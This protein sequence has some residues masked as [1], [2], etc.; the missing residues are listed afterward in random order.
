MHVVQ[1]PNHKYHKLDTILGIDSSVKIGSCHEFGY[2]LNTTMLNIQDFSIVKY[3]KENGVEILNGM[4]SMVAKV[5]WQHYNCTVQCTELDASS[6]CFYAP[7][8]YHKATHLRNN[9]F[10]PQIVILGKK[11]IIFKFCENTD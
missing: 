10:K 2:L 3:D 6:V 11:I 9:T 8:N 5:C 7:F 1:L 4:P